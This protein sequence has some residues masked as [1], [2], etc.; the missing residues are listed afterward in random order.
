MGMAGVPQAIGE[1]N[2]PQ[3]AMAGAPQGT[4]MPQ[5]YPGVPPN[6]AQISD[7]QIYAP[8]QIAPGVRVP[9]QYPQVPQNTTQID[10]RLNARP[11]QT[12]YIDPGGPSAAAPAP[13]AVAPVED[14]DGSYL[15]DGLG[16][17][18]RTK[19]GKKVRVKKFK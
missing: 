5:Q 15:K 9:P 16:R 3:M 17:P 10:D 14:D 19:D 1:M 2:Q 18:V 6:T 13:A 8:D 7:Q 11:V 12:Q 4:P